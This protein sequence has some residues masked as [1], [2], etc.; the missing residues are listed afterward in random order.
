MALFYTLPV[1]KKLLELTKQFDDST[2]KVPQLVKHDY[3]RAMH[4]QLVSIVTTVAFANEFNA[5]RGKLLGAA[6][7]SLA[8]FKIRVRVLLDLH[9]ITKK[10]FAA[11]VRLEESAA[12]QLPCSSSDHESRC[13]GSNSSTYAKIQGSPL[14]RQ[15]FLQNQI[16]A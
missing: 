5:D 14:R 1:Y 15:L 2:K 11:I 6:V 12:K 4:N 7:T 8:E 3:V 13:K 16:C 9:Y 10:G